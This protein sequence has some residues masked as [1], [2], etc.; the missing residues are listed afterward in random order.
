M[1][2]RNMR[3]NLKMRLNRKS[4][5]I[6]AAIAGI[7]FATVARATTFTTPEFEGAQIEPGDAF[8]DDGGAFLE[9]RGAANQ[10]A[11]FGIMDFNAGALNIPSGQQVTSV[12]PTMNLTLHIDNFDEPTQNQTLSFFLATDTNQAEVQNGS[13]LLSWEPN[14]T[15][16]GG[17]NSPGQP[18]SFAAGTQL[19]SLG[20][21]TYTTGQADATALPVS[22]TLNTAEQQAIQQEVNTG[23]TVRLVVATSETD[24]GFTSFY[25]FANSATAN[26]PQ[27]SLDLNTGVGSSNTSRLFVN[28]AGT[29]TASINVGTML[30]D[31]GAPQFCVLQGGSATTSVTLGNSST[32]TGDNLTYTL[33][34]TN[35]SASV[36]SPGPDPIVPGGTAKATVGFGAS[37]TALEAGNAITGSVTITNNSNVA[38]DATPVTVNINP[39]LV[40]QERFVDSLGGST[41]SPGSAPN[42]GK[43]LVGTTGSVTASITTDNPVNLNDFT[44][45]ALTTVTLNPN[46]T[47]TPFVVD[48]FFTKQPVGTITATSPNSSVGTTFDGTESENVSGHVA[49]TVS[50]IYGNNTPVTENGVTQNY[51]PNFTA[52]GQAAI[53][54]DGLAG[55]NDSMDVYLQWQGYQAASVTANTSPSSP[56]VV[57]ANSTAMATL[58]NAATNDNIFMTNN[59]GLRAGAVVTNTGSFDQ[60]WS[61]GG[62]TLAGFTDNSAIPGSQSVGDPD[63][64]GLSATVDFN[65]SNQMINGTYGETLIVDL[66]NEQD[67]QGATANDLAPVVFNLQTAVN[68]A[69]GTGA[70]TYTLS[71]GTLV[72]GPTHLTGSFT[73]TGGKSTFTNITGTGQLAISGG[74]VTLASGGGDSAVS[75]LSISGGGLLDIANNSMIIS[76]AAGTQSTTDA[77]IRGYLVSG[78][79]GG[80]LAGASG[81]TSSTAAVTPGFAV[82][83][84]DGADGVVSGLSSG[85]IELKYTLYGD[86]NLDGVVSGDDFSILVGNLGKSD[87]AWDKGDFN[88]DGVVSGDDFSLLVGNLGKAANGADI[89]I[90]AGDLAAIDAF[91]AANGL[92]ADVPEP[93]SMGILALSGIAI[94]SRRTRRMRPC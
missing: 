78:Y 69:N 33:T 38:T 57:T 91:A 81:I 34:N 12:N 2:E 20:S 7:S 50:G 51:T 63:S 23:G 88:Y 32:T 90:P 41:N 66:E 89:A 5:A 62:W 29:K 60:T 14:S 68:D 64:H 6:A 56:L 11:D 93:A 1:Q 85:Q 46:M 37:N 71:G 83:Y 79:A 47:S 76:Y 94:L 15:F 61:S 53:T 74:S 49:V 35:A 16:A 54:G 43:V 44:N 80:T 45:D 87:A 67:I 72:A 25:S 59:N 19:F 42:V 9:L 31:H 52:F 10:F 22:F 36:T 75:S 13:T 86:A 21:T 4:G 82:G 55:E 3:L 48:D 8:E 30:T 26:I 24:G 77:T 28:T 73:Q 39:T 92:L 70:G 58:T 40:L 27:L 84:A 18:G 65:A 17:L